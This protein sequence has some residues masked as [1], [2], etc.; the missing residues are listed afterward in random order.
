MVDNTDPLADLDLKQ[1]IDLR[2]TLRD[3]RGKRWKMSPIDQG[4]LKTLIEMGLVEMRD[5]E[6]ALT[7]RG[8]DAII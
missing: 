6:P 4:Q 2:W 1:A 3:I 8:L 5:D 7:H